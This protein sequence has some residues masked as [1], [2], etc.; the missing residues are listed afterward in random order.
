MT[1]LFLAIFTSHI[2]ERRVFY[3]KLFLRFVTY[4]AGACLGAHLMDKTIK[5]ASNPVNKAKIK[6]KIAKMLHVED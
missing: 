2:M 6:R 4:G 1:L 3:M 5:A